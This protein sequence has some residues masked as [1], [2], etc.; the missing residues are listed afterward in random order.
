M[1][2]KSK[3]TIILILGIVFAAIYFAIFIFNICITGDVNEKLALLNAKYGL[4]EAETVDSALTEKKIDSLFFREIS[5]TSVLNVLKPKKELIVKLNDENNVQEGPLKNIFVLKL[6]TDSDVKEIAKDYE[7]IDLVAYAEPNYELEMNAESV[8][9]L[10][11][12]NEPKEA[13]EAPEDA[14]KNLIVTVALIDSGIDANHKDLKG[15]IIQGWNFMNG[16]SIT[17]DNV[18]HGTHIAGIIARNSTFAKIMPL[19][20]TDGK[21]GGRIS[22]LIKA[23]K[24]ASDKN[25]NIINL[26]LGLQEKSKSLEEATAYAFVKG[27]IV[28]AAAGNYNSENEYYPAAFNNVFAVAALNKNREKLYQSDFGKW[29]DYSTEAQDVLSSLPGDRYG[30]A[31]GTSQAT[32]FLTAKIADII[33]TNNIFDS[34]RINRE[35]RKASRIINKGEFSGML[36]RELL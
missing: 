13:L 15:R 5:M 34:P 14:P 8:E 12:T 21:N 24:F 25:V 36:G 31:T 2:M 23:I 16:S 10:E 28:V 30:Y 35:L 3:K 27:A 18:G 29:V 33:A 1:K 22:D 7:N 17:D 11:D 20:F 9:L 32:P 6:R 26:S 19:K 4:T